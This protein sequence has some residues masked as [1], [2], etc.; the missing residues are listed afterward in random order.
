MTG[1]YTDAQADHG[2]ETYMGVCVGCHPAG[3]YSGETFKASWT[4]RPL[5]DLFDTIK[6]KMPKNDPGS[7]S[8][9]QAAQLVSYILRINK[10]PPGKTD[11]PAEV[12]PLKDIRI[13][14]PGSRRK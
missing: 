10:V 9:E 8:P 4:G 1:V 5:S 12:D 7:L 11:L 2:E 14:M 13:E 3:T 6:E